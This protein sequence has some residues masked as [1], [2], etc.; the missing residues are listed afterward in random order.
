MGANEGRNGMKNED[1][2]PPYTAVTQHA[3]FP[4]PTHDEVA[5]FNFL[6]NFNRFMA[7]ALGPGNILT[8]E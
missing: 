7:T 6:A 2:A 8:Y 4:K 1:I 3:V 5:R